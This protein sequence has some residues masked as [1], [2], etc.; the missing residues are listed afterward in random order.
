MREVK[1]LRR[2]TMS[3]WG[4]EQLT[5][6]MKLEPVPRLTDRGPNMI[7]RGQKLPVSKAS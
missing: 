1:A 7:I 4:Q 6:L 3:L 2:S 5:K